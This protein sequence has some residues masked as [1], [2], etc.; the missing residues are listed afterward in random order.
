M[1]EALRVGDL[2]ENLG[3]AP[4]DQH[5]PDPFTSNVAPS[6]TG[7]AAAENGL[8]D[9]SPE[10][11]PAVLS[12]ARDNNGVPAVEEQA[13]EQQSAV[14]PSSTASASSEST[15]AS[16]SSAAP[17]PTDFGSSTG[18]AIGSL[19]FSDDGHDVTCTLPPTFSSSQVVA[20]CDD[21]GAREF[22]AADLM[23]SAV[24][25]IV[26]ASADRVWTV[27]TVAGQTL[28]VTSASWQTLVPE[29]TQETTTAPETTDETAP[30]TT[31]P[32]TTAAETASGTPETTDSP[33]AEAE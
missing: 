18:D 1:I 19:T 29:T 33:S 24:T 17:T 7:D 5:L 6:F 16:E 22:A 20:T 26:A 28:T 23:E 31:A 21:G 8:R 3:P 27:S 12:A 14:D 15:E 11:A 13:G 25:Q 9:G 4:A 2:L 10:A 30:E 32:D